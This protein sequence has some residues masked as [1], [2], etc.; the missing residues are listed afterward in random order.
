MESCYAAVKSVWQPK[1]GQTLCFLCFVLCFCS[2][3]SIKFLLFF[4]LKNFFLFFFIFYFIF[5]F[6]MFDEIFIRKRKKNY[7]KKKKERKN[8]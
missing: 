3:A 4:L 5:T 8:F 2:L 7:V 6:Y 1:V